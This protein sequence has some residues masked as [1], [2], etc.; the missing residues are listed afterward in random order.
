MKTPIL[1]IN[2][3]HSV[4]SRIFFLTGRALEDLSKKEVLYKS[5]EVAIREEPIK[6]ISMEMYR[7]K[8]EFVPQSYGTDITLEVPEGIVLKEGDILY[9]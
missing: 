1:V 3:V 2:Y 9:K 4:K 5:D 6:I 8:V 7:E